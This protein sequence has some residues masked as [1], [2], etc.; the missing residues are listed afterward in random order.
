MLIGSVS[1]FITNNYS[2]GSSPPTINLLNGLK[3]YWGLN[4]NLN[5]SLGQNN[6]SWVQV[7]SGEW[8]NGK[9]NDCLY[10]ASTIV[11]LGS[12]AAIKPTTAITIAGWFNFQGFG[13]NGVRFAAD[14]HQSTLLDRWLFYN[15]HNTYGLKFFTYIDGIQGETFFITPNK[16]FSD[17]AYKWLYLVATWSTGDY[18]RTYVNGAP[19][20]TSSQTFN[21]PLPAGFTGNV[22]IGGQVEAPSSAGVYIDEFAIWDRALTPEEV[23][24]LYNFG[25]GIAYPF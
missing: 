22:T 12:A 4:V 17:I 24:Y 23:S 19:A 2:T 21:G 10:A 11:S 18:V 3:G 8:T 16:Y 9:I 13:N 5:D 14:W 20:Y 7:G 15:D 25:S 1:Q 6:G